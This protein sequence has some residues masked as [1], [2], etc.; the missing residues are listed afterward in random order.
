MRFYCLPLAPRINND[1]VLVQGGERYCMHMDPLL[2]FHK[3]EVKAT[4]MW[5]LHEKEIAEKNSHI[6]KESLRAKWKKLFIVC[7]E[8]CP[9]DDDLC[10]SFSIQQSGH[11][12]VVVPPDILNAPELSADESVTNEGGNV[13]LMCQATGVPEPRLV[14]QR[15]MIHFNLDSHGN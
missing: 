15:Y 6:G 13:Q 9:D 14:S 8:E 7:G 11:L 4:R 2:S 5:R 10:F 12:D 1:N 3:S